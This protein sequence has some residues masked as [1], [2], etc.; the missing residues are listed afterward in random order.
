L[1]TTRGN[2][3]P[4]IIH[5]QETE[6]KF[7]LVQGFRPNTLVPEDDWFLKELKKRKN[8]KIIGRDKERRNKVNK[9]IT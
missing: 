8:D 9:R 6:K 3:I 2:I 1:Q 5:Q 4:R 7:H